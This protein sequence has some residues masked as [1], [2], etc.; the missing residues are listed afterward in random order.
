MNEIVVGVD[1][2]RSA[3]AAVLWAA[4]Q[5]RATARICAP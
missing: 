4:E 2:S 5:A 1:L 3:S